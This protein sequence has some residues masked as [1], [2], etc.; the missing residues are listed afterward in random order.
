MA[1]RW[2]NIPETFLCEAPDFDK[3]QDCWPLRDSVFIPMCNKRYI[4]KPKNKE[5]GSVS[6]K[7]D[8]PMSLLSCSRFSGWIPIWSMDAIPRNPSYSASFSPLIFL[9]HY[10]FLISLYLWL[11][12]YFS[13]DPDS[14]PRPSNHPGST[15]A[16]PRHI[17]ASFTVP[18]VS[19]IFLKRSL[20]LSH[21]VLFLYF[22]ALITE[23]GFL[24]FPCCSLE[25]FIQMSVSFLFSFSFKFSSFS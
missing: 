4:S 12:M 22:F 14:V 5:F 17:F 19:I 18:L 2:C 3:G 6:G 13:K 15:G 21:S 23:E 25:L 9:L 8:S 16:G 7:T 1:R 10:P 20:S 24:I 11:N